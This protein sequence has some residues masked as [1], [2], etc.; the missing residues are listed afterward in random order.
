MY[1]KNTAILKVVTVLIRYSSA[2]DGERTSYSKSFLSN[3]NNL[4]QAS[5]EKTDLQP[6][7]SIE[8][9]CPTIRLASRLVT[10]RYTSS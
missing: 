8:D 7:V 3:S 10:T 2:T 5:R 9:E 1:W 4:S 6:G